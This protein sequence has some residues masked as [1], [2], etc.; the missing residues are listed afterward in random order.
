MYFAVFLQ[1]R[2][3]HVNPENYFT[4]EEIELK[5]LPEVIQLNH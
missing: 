2:F 1:W 5:L 4:A 3:G